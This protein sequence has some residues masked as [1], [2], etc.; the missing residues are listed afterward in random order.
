[1]HKLFK[2]TTE[3]VYIGTLLDY[4]MCNFQ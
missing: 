3:V 4:I 1:M 2:P